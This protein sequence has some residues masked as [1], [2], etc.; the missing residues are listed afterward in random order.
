MSHATPGAPARRLGTPEFVALMAM[1][2]A[3]I[4]FSIDAMLPALPVIAAELTPA[5]PNAA[6]LIVV[7]FVLGMGAGTLVAG[8]LSDAFGRKPVML[9][10]AA[11]YCAAAAV[12]TVL[13]TLEGVVAARLVQGL[14]A[15]GPRVVA[16]AMIRDLYAGRG[17]AR[18]ASYVMMVFTL[19]PAVAPL[20]GA[21]IVAGFGWR[22]I[23]WAFVLFS[24]LSAAWLAL[25]QPETL[26]PAMRRP[27]RLGPLADAAREVVRRP[28][29]RRA[30]LA[31]TLVFSV[32]FS[33]L[34][35][36]QPI[37]DVTF[38]RAES[39]PLWLGGVA[40]LSGA[41]SLLNAQ[42]V[43]RVGMAWL[44]RRALAGHLTLTLGL[45]T[46]WHLLPED[47]DFAAFL[48]WQTGSFALAGMTIGN[49][50][51]IAMEPLGHVAGMASSVI[52]SA[53]TVGAVILAAP[54]GLMFDGTPQPLMAGAALFSGAALW[55][56]AGL[57]EGRAD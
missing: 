56:A 39:F 57:R 30:V 19:V 17:M 26:P 3:T 25:R 7:G 42:L 23:F 32:L 18:I 28:D 29:T 2:A 11:L 21:G 36:L 51:A 16:L 43:E 40:L 8:P 45:L 13:P 35:S 34:V 1:L 9:A 44:L 15:A 38:G 24:A 54:V 27:M 41:A 49:L 20:I 46:L 6:Q 10:G 31:Q 33:V 53:A 52:S 50:N 47:A 5:A 22:G 14:G 55:L 12:A 48:V 37:Y 4:A